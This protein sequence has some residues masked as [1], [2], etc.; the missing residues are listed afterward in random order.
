M[1]RINHFWFFLTLSILTGSGSVHCEEESVKQVT[2]DE[3]GEVWHSFT[4]DNDLFVGND[5][6]YTNGLYFS[7]FDLDEGKDSWPDPGLLLGPL[8]GSMPA[9]DDTLGAVS[10]FTIGQTMNTPSDITIEIPAG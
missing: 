8:M 3:V 2:N 1:F 9:R 6:G 5:S 10:S 4:L 7:T